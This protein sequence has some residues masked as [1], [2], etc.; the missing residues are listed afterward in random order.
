MVTPILKFGLSQA[1]LDDLT[2]VFS[3]FPNIEL[4][5]L[6]G[7]RAKNTFKD[8]SDIDLAVIAP[9]LNDSQFSAL[10]GKIEDLP[11]AFKVDLLHWDTLSNQALKQKIRSEG[12]QLYPSNR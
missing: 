3:Q 2:R 10:W 1:I 7:S 12:I 5:L 4:V 8:G 11:L 6:F 9:T